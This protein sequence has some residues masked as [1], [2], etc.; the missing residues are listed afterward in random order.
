VLLNNL[1]VV[2]SFATIMLGISLLIMVLTQTVSTLLNL[3]GRN[4][5]AGLV[6]LFK[7]SPLQESV[8]AQVAKTILANPL[9]A[10]GAFFSRIAPAIR[11]EELLA[12]IDQLKT[13]QF[14]H[15]ATELE[16][17]KQRI[18]TWFQSSMDRVSHRFAGWMRMITV[19]FSFAI[20]FGLHLDSLEILGRLSS[21]PALR[22]SLAGLSQNLLDR[23]QQLKVASQD[24][25]AAS[26]TPQELERLIG[27]A[28]GIAASFEQTPFQLF[29]KQ[30]PDFRFLQHFWGILVSAVLL[31]LG[32]PFWFNVLGV[33]SSLRPVLATKVD[34]EPRADSQ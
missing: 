21:D 2:L 22:N 23:A 19:L 20:A 31:S 15:A 4:L 17:A 13:T 16:E 12:M 28:K 25:T 7:E 24:S 11:K 5:L 1:D 33:A 3:R 34:R 8:G 6:L 14:K 9:L 18:E 29:A 10:D 27:D 26:A 30:D 32:A